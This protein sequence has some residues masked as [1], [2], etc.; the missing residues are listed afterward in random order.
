MIRKSIFLSISLA[1][2]LATGCKDKPETQSQDIAEPISFTKEAEAYLTR[3]GGDTIQFLQLEIADDD[4]QRETGLMY[5]ETMEQDQGMLF[6]FDNE[7]PRGFYMKN[8]NIPLDLI[9][10]NAENKIVS[11]KKNA[12]PKSLETIPSEVPAQYVLEVNA[13]LS[14]EWGLQ[15]GDSLIL[16][17][18]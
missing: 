4:Y 18:D 6:I 13:G 15:V 12:K 17:R 9:F 3:P 1:G 2:I 5:R 11:I 8:T 14:D 7:Q 10:L 16:N